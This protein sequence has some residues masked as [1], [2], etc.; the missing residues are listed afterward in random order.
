MISGGWV[1][2]IN[3]GNFSALMTTGFYYTLVMMNFIENM[4][5][6]I[7]KREEIASFRNLTGVQANGKCNLL[8]VFNLGILLNSLLGVL[9]FNSFDFYSMLG[10]VDGNEKERFH[11][12]KFWKQ[13]VYNIKIVMV[14]LV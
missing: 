12:T 8:T 13:I 9:S 1:Y 4:T 7:L 2:S 5:F 10:K 3:L 14:Y 11:Q 6:S